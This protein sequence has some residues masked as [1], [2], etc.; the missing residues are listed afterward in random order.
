MPPNMPGRAVWHPLL[1][2]SMEI[3]YAHL[4]SSHDTRFPGKLQLRLLQPRSCELHQ[5]DN[6]MQLFEIC[7]SQVFE[8]I[9]QRQL[10]TSGL[11]HLAMP[12]A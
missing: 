12:T 4:L 6:M 11:L 10:S 8:A 2:T 1:V 7:H 5:L 3:P 9:L